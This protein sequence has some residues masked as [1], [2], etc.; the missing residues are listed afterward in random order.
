MQ[1]AVRRIQNASPPQFVHVLIL[2]ENKSNQLWSE[3]G[4]SHKHLHLPAFITSRD[5]A[6][7]GHDYYFRA[8]GTTYMSMIALMLRFSKLFLPYCSGHLFVHSILSALAVMIVQELANCSLFLKDLQHKTGYP[9]RELLNRKYAFIL[10]CKTEAILVSSTFFTLSNGHNNTM[11]TDTELL[12]RALREHAV[13]MRQSHNVGRKNT[14]KKAVL[15][16]LRCL[17]GEELAS[18]CCVGDVGFVKTLLHMAALSR[19][20]KLQEFQV[21]PFI[22]ITTTLNQMKRNPT[23]TLPRTAPRRGS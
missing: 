3:T 22:S 20:T 5:T 18:L 12:V 21:L 2:C 16:W 9:I 10:H 6:A 17:S 15:R 7:V 4:Y 19:G 13:S 11:A 14:E 1:P 8:C 23:N